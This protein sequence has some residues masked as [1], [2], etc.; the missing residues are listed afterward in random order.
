MASVY[1][2]TATKANNGKIYAFG[3]RKELDGRPV[4]EGGYILFVVKSNYDGKKRGGMD[5]RWVVVKQN[6]SYADAVALMNAK[7]G[8]QAY[9]ER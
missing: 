8:Y 5:K 1:S 6:M 7:C 3:R 4:A 2:K 9:A